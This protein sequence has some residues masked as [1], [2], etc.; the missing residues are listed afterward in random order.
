MARTKKRAT[1]FFNSVRKLGKKLTSQS[2]RF[3]NAKRKKSRKLTKRVKSKI[4]NLGK[5]KSN[6]RIQYGCNSKKM[7]GGGPAFQ[8]LTDITRNFSGTSND[9]YNTIMGNDPTRN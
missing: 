7:R 3:L 1:K 2:K 5:R 8:P 4:R 9:V 6:K